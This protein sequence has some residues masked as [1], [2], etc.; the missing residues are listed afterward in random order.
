MAGNSSCSA[1]RL[2]SCS[3]FRHH[4]TLSVRFDGRGLL[5][6]VVNNE[7]RAAGVHRYGHGHAAQQGRLNT[8]KTACSWNDGG[9]VEPICDIAY[10]VPRL[11]VRN[12]PLRPESGGMR[13]LDATV[14]LIL[15]DG[16][17]D[18]VELEGLREHLPDRRVQDRCGI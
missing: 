15:G 2:R 8:G 12:A 1:G 5:C 3:W 11:A 14:H 6:W 16:L 18:L 17:R 7:D 4:C 9:G 10:R 13:E